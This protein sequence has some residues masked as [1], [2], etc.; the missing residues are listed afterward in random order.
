MADLIQTSPTSSTTIGG[1]SP[2]VP[3]SNVP[4]PAPT[5][6][7][8]VAT[9]SPLYKKA[10]SFVS[11]FI[12]TGGLDLMRLV[13]NA[14]VDDSGLR[15][16]GISTGF[17][18]VVDLLTA[19]GYTYT[20]AWDAVSGATKWVSEHISLG[21]PQEN[22]GSVP[23]SSWLWFPRS[24][25]AVMTAEERAALF[26][27]VGSANWGAAGAMA[28]TLLN[29]PP[30]PTP[31]PTG[32]R[33][34]VTVWNDAGNPV[35]ISVPAGSTCKPS[36]EPGFYAWFN[37]DGSHETMPYGF[38][39]FDPATQPPHD[40]GDDDGGSDQRIDTTGG[41]G[42]LYVDVARLRGVLPPGSSLFVTVD[43]IEVTYPDG[44]KAFFSTYMTQ[45]EAEALVHK[46]TMF[47]LESASFEAWATPFLDN[48]AASYQRLDD[49]S[50]KLGGM[51]AYAAPMI[52]TYNGAVATYNSWV[53]HM[54]TLLGSEKAALDSRGGKLSAL[55]E[56]HNSD[57]DLYTAES[58]ASTEALN[59][60]KAKVDR[61]TARVEKERAEVDALI[62][63]L[64]L[65]P[66]DKVF[67][68]MVEK[69]QAQLADM[70]KGLNTLVDTY[71]KNAA[72]ANVKYGDWHEELEKRRVDIQILQDSL[73][74]DIDLYNSKLEPYESQASE[75]KAA[76]DKKDT[77]LGE[78]RDSIAAMDTELQAMLTDYE[79]LLGSTTLAEIKDRQA[80]LKAR[81]AEL[82]LLVSAHDIDLDIKEFTYRQLEELA[83]QS[84]A[85]MMS[86]WA[87]LNED[88]TWSNL[89]QAF[90]PWNE[91]AG[92]TFT[93]NKY[94]SALVDLAAKLDKGIGV[95]PV[96]EHIST[97]W[98]HATPWHE[99]IGETLTESKYTRAFETAVAPETLK[100]GANMM[101][102]ILLPVYG[103]V[104][105]WNEMSTGMKVLSVVT[106]IMSI[107]PVAGAVG[108]GAR[109]ASTATDAT[110]NAARLTRLNSA[111]RAGFQ[112]AV[113]EITWPAELLKSLKGLGAGKVLVGGV[114]AAS[115]TYVSGLRAVPYNM[116]DMA[117]MAAGRLKATASGLETAIV[118]W[119][120]PESVVSDTWGTLRMPLGRFDDADQAF[121]ARR[122]L[123]EAASQ[124]GNHLIVETPD[125]IIDIKRADI[126]AELGG[127][128][129]H[130]TPDGAS[131]VGGTV[132]T[133]KKGMP[134]I[135]QGLFLSPEAL[136]RFS[137][138]SAFGK[139]QKSKPAIIIVAPETA[140]KAGTTRKVYRSTA[141]MEAVLGVGTEVPEAQQVLYTRLGHSGQRVEI[142]L[143]KKLSAA[144]IA[145]LKAKGLI[146]SVTNVFDP[147]I[148]ITSKS[149]G[150]LTKADIDDLVRM[151]NADG[152]REAARLLN[153]VAENPTSVYRALA[154]GQRPTAYQM[155]WE[156]RGGEPRV[157]FQEVQMRTGESLD[158]FQ[159][160]LEDM[161]TRMTGVTRLTE[162]VDALDVSRPDRAASMETV[163][164]R[165]SEAERPEVRDREATP[166]MEATR[167]EPIR[168]DARTPEATRLDTTRVE[169]TRLDTIR[170]EPTR[171]D[172]TRPVTPARTD[173][174]RAGEPRTE[175]ERMDQSRTERSAD[176]EQRIENGRV[177][178][179]KETTRPRPMFEP[180]PPPPLT[181]GNVEVKERGCGGCEV[182]VID[183]TFIGFGLSP[184]RDTRV[185]TGE[186]MAQSVA[187]KQGFC[188]KLW[189]PPFGPTDVV[190]SLEPFPGVP[191]LSG[192][193]S[194]YDSLVA[195]G[196]IPEDAR[197]PMGVFDVMGSKVGEEPELEYVRKGK[198]RRKSP[199]NAAS[200]RKLP[201][202]A[203]M[204]VSRG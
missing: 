157:E 156:T 147:S 5:P 154:E 189:H 174:T 98:Q 171:T 134:D 31:T 126:M 145:K 70:V 188:Y 83:A 191:T 121:E 138:S 44:T 141:E 137:E 196:K 129:A 76:L 58:Q 153:R 25:W 179:D 167:V 203:S 28:G 149:G 3:V 13:A 26:G 132:V 37:P 86:D 6:T 72:D 57:S 104:K 56:V 77:E 90:T 144:S 159:A 7:S 169:P 50:K 101:A 95:S 116:K 114:D 124:P 27:A 46:V 146:N 143:G 161:E 93:E 4:P 184:K 24:E 118:P 199:R 75:R 20:D 111:A 63:Q 176:R 96:A 97:A 113:K 173:I 48:M 42:E 135:E 88:P 127:G 131:F 128:M 23:G 193:R 18:S 69:R 39:P 109:L 78:L 68:A 85:S 198:S 33:V 197:L 1:S 21:F 158:Q 195:S 155:V 41:G 34:T 81:E 200:R 73:T 61:E 133:Y 14:K 170:G 52:R 163:D 180:P 79:S 36:G 66:D 38:T 47:N 84:Q 178:R 125:M 65:H 10:S 30:T 152:E 43:G 64:S 151:M 55:I 51:V 29:L 19:Y 182:N 140:A 91:R 106:D 32:D 54:E 183:N 94:S 181:R 148:T 22:G 150:N 201:Q 168:E 53:S 164:F 102:D 74:A 49:M 162:R 119:K 17:N 35:H 15:I 40:F 122:L 120:L 11:R 177:V 59:R 107:V 45:E 136:P 89:W 80:R 130:A 112:A 16:E 60:E 62:G 117:A 71:N 108:K 67:R 194:A 185:L 139:A 165:V 105:H 187:W 2:L 190:S 87:E 192:P 172:T 115:S 204:S 175:V 100:M 166:S 160:R 12:G 110:I 123:M 202:S 186:Q 9:E 103:T 99:A 142:Q 82:A 92:E 8:T